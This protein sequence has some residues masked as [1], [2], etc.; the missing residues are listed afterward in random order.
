MVTDHVD[1]RLFDPTRFVN[2]FISG[3]Q[4]FEACQLLG[5]VRL[6]DPVQLGSGAPQHDAVRVRVPLSQRSH[7]HAPEDAAALHVARR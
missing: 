6:E 7:Q 3:N 5:S 2:S 4:L 1:V